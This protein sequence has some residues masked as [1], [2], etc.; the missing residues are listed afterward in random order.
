[1]ADKLTLYNDA[2]LL[3]G[4]RFLSSLT[5]NREPR[6]LLDQAWNSGDGI[7]KWLEEA[8]WEFAMRTVQLDYDPSI[9]PGFGYNRGFNK[10]TDWVITSAVCS[11]EYFRSPLT[12]YV[13]E[14]GYWFSD[15]DILF[16]RYISND[17]NYGGNL[18]LWPGSF[19]R[20][21]AADLADRIIN[22]LSNSDNEHMRVRKVRGQ[23]LVM[24]K[25]KAAMAGPTSFPGRGNWGLARN[26]FPYRRDG[27]NSSGSLIG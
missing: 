22:K 4:E 10:P 26:R 8:Q 7:N 13:D 12:R 6:L 18:G 15:L 9:T 20:F 11:D 19:Q 21:V 1:M 17:T 23:E 25:N 2:L 5:E 3:C 14:A 27:G 24:A 16:I